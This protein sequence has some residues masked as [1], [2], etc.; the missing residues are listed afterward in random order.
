MATLRC[1]SQLTEVTSSSKR[2]PPLLRP[3]RRDEL[4]VHSEPGHDKVVQLLLEHGADA[5]AKVCTHPVDSLS[6]V[7]HD[8]DDPRTKT[9]T[10]RS[11]WLG[12][13]NTILSSLSCRLFELRVPAIA[14]ELH[15]CCHE[16]THSRLLH[17]DTTH[18]K[19]TCGHRSQQN[20]PPRLPCWNSKLL[21]VCCP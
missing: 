19:M 20:K 9:A 1:I 2:P 18:C 6:R 8:L 7:I 21:P 12:W 15:V 11:I 5:N 3:E 17:L 10:R 16:Y 4:I 14:A 13:Q